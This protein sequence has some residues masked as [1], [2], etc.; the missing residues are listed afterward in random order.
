MDLLEAGQAFIPI[1]TGDLPAVLLGMAV[2]VLD[3]P[4]GGRL[5]GRVARGR[6]DARPGVDADAYRH[7]EYHT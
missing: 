5:N 2:A 1:D 3:L 4:A 6:G 7:A